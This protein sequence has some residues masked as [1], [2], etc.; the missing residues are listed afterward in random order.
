MA[1]SEAGRKVGGGGGALKVVFGG[2]H[3]DF[4]RFLADVL[5][6]YRVEG[7]SL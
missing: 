4:F 5:M 2:G 6:A 3:V 7:V 1:R